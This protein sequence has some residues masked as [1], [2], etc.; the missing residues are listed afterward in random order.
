MKRH[1][2]TIGLVGGLALLTAGCSSV[3]DS[4]LV[5]PASME[6][7]A[8]APNVP[9]LCRSSLGSYT[10]PKTY[11]KVTVWREG[12]KTLPNLQVEELRRADPRLVFCLDHMSDPMAEDQI[13]V[14]K[15]SGQVDNTYT[16]D[17]D[18][19]AVSDSVGPSSASVGGY[20]T[21]FLQWVVSTSL[22]QSEYIFKTLVR[23]AF[24]ALSKNPN[25][26]TT[27]GARKLSTDSA[28]NNTILAVLEYDPF[29]TVSAAR[30]NSRLRDFGYCLVLDGFTYDG[31]FTS[32]GRY[33]HTPQAAP[34]ETPVYKAYVQ[35]QQEPPP[36]VVNGIAYRPRAA[37]GLAIY[38]K[39]DPYGRG[40]WALKEMRTV[41]LENIS[42]VVSVGVSRSVFA[43]RRI[44]LNFEDGV[45]KNMC[46]Q[47]TSE[48][49]SAVTIPYVIVQSIVAL[50]SQAIALEIDS[51]NAN[52]QLVDIETQI[53]Q[54][55]QAQIQAIS[56]DNKDRSN[57]G[58]AAATL[59]DASVFASP[60]ALTDVAT[61]KTDAIFT[62]PKNK[63]A[64]L[65]RICQKA[66]TVIQ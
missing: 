10:L 39:N 57:K 51:Y 59:P 12:D 17:A 9:T 8:Y 27:T 40:V 26:T 4:T 52:S 6:S 1:A 23:A 66:P 21:Q 29:D 55:Q 54:T 2:T 62:D 33:C 34:I 36:P 31:S 20:G 64:V 42:P 18:G 35:L 45:L 56:G 7:M 16:H 13:R 14:I 60:N 48:L 46:L 22:D 53:L 37:Y 38:Q 58:K 44:V 15:A 49:Q 30:V 24:V 3:A 5:H 43:Q 63:N 41:R 28:G 47:K 65:E 19:K 11:L 61:L 50:P 32:H 25:F